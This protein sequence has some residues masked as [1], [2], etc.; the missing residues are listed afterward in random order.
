MIVSY[1]TGKRITPREFV[2]NWSRKYYVYNSGMSWSLPQAAATHYNLG[3]VEQTT[4]TS[5]MV[6]ALKNNQPVMSSQSSGLFTSGGHL[7]VLRG[8]TS[9]GKIL[10]NDPNKSNAVGKGYNNKR[11]SVEQINASNKV[12]FIFPKKK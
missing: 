6:Q 12:Y 10:V 5:R 7:I 2:G 4:W 8:V 9:N 3:K 1:L 11:F